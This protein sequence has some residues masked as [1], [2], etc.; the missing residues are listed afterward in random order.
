MAFL[1]FSGQ[2][3]ALYP[4]LAFSPGASSGVTFWRRGTF[5]SGG[6]HSLL[7]GSCKSTLHSLDEG[8]CELLGENLVGE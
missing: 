8:H 3:A 1:V 7:F 2:E 5:F 6:Q 4:G